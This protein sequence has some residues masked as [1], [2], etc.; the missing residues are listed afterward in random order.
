M[1]GVPMWHEAVGFACRAHAGHLRK[2]GQTPYVSHV[3]RVALTVRDVFGCDDEVCLCAALLHDV[4]EDTPA[5]YDE[6]LEG[7]GEV[8]AKAVAALTKDMRLP[9][10]ERE[11]A[12]DEGLARAD[13]RAK[14]IKLADVLDNF[15]DRK[16]TRA[17]FNE[18]KHLDKCRRALSVA[19]AES[20][21]NAALQ[22][23]IEAVER[24]IEG[25]P[26]L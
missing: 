22:R 14:L 23:G 7:F 26:S 25:A 15:H 2:D 17:D 21:P 8:T 3:V 9:E 24:L 18:A 6:I 11:R 12:Y 20:E 16:R 1:A 13:W 5:D 4:I 10:D 19:R